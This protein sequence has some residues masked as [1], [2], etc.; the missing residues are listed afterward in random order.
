MFRTELVDW[1]S[2][3][4]EMIFSGKQKYSLCTIFVCIQSTAIDEIGKILNCKM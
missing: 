2:D 1:I 4:D 3:F